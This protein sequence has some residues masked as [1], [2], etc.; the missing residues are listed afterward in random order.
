MVHRYVL[1]AIKLYNAMVNG[2]PMYMALL[3]HSISNGLERLPGVRII[4]IQ[5]VWLCVLGGR[6]AVAC[7]P[8]SW[9]SSLLVK[10]A[11]RWNVGVPTDYDWLW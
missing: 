3:K 8:R 6:G 7:L 10:S 2:G 1:S 5:P 9:R 11:G 4:R